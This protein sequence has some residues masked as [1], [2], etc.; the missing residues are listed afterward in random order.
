MPEIDLPQVPLAQ[1][2]E[3]YSQSC[4]TIDGL[5]FSLVEQKYGTDSALAIDVEVWRLLGR[6]QAKRMIEK[7][8]IRE[9]NPLL[10][11]IKA[12][13][14]DPITPIYKPVVPFLDE[15]RAVFRITDCPPQK[16]RLKDGRGLFPCRE[17]GLAYYGTY[18]EVVDPRIKLT[19]Q[20]CPPE[21]YDADRWCE[22]QFEIKEGED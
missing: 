4:Y 14:M 2:R 5:W 17:V 10:T 6:I 15:N 9:S 7:F 22:W 18:A 11:L 19:C 20:A 3:T 16:A 8:A 13:L 1:L 21:K 12:L